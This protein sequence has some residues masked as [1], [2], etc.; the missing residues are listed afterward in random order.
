MS[1]SPPFKK[2]EYQEEDFGV[3]GCGDALTEVGKRVLEFIHEFYEVGIHDSWNWTDIA[4]TVEE[5]GREVVVSS[6][7][8]VAV[9]VQQSIVETRRSG[10]LSQTTHRRL[11]KMR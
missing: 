2:Y 6:T 1:S 9:G 8:R 7:A 10:M 11:G 3:Q 4:Q 5:G